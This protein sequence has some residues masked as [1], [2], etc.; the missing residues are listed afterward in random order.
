MGGSKNVPWINDATN[1]LILCASDHLFLVEIERELAYRN[2]WLVHRGTDPG[3]VPVVTYKGLFYLTADG[4]YVPV[5]GS[6]AHLEAGR[7]LAGLAGA[8]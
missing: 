8:S 3:S 4:A 7:G 2:G 1:I 6:T 5:L